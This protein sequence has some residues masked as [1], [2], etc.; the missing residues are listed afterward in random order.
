VISAWEGSSE[1]RAELI[2]ASARLIRVVFWHF[3][4]AIVVAVSSAP[5]ISQ[6]RVYHLGVL[7]LHRS[8]RHPL[9]G[10]R[11]GLR[12]AGYIEGKNLFLERPL[13]TNPDDLRDAANNFVHEKRDASV[14]LRNVETRIASETRRGIP[15]VFMPASDPVRA[16]PDTC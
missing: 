10:L 11:D 13:K 3:L 1:R 6:A 7:T 8:E 14:I 16:F 4:F 15:V 2:P 5:V 12:E 9:K